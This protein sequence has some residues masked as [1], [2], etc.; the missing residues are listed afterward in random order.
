[1]TAFVT[2]ANVSMTYVFRLGPR[3]GENEM[4]Y[5]T[6]VPDT[7]S[8][9]YAGDGMVVQI[10]TYN[11]CGC[12]PG[13]RYRNSHGK[14]LKDCSSGDANHFSLLYFIY[15]EFRYICSQFYLK[16]S[17]LG[18]QFRLKLQYKAEAGKKVSSMHRERTPTGSCTA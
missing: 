6:C 4:F 8:C 10:C 13:F 7:E 5:R 18:Q 15:I 2:A 14:C 17:C 1:M 3:C 16:L 12:K 9:D 11:T